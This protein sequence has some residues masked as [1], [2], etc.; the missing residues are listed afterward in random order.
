MRSFN[1]PWRNLGIGA[2]FALMLFA[3]LLFLLIATTTQ[4]RAATKTMLFLPQILPGIPIKPQEILL[5]SPVREAIQYPIA[6]GLGEADLYI[7]KRGSSHAGILLF[8]GVAPAGQD[9]PRVIGLAESLARSG[10]VVMIPWS[11]TMTQKRIAVEEVDN[12]VHAFQ[13]LQ[14]LDDTDPK[15]IGMSGFCVGA[16]LTTVAAQDPRIAKDV[17]FINFFGGYYDAKLLL[18]S[19]LTQHRFYGESTEPWAPNKLGVEVVQSHLIEGLDDSA[20]RD[21]LQKA[22]SEG[23]LPSPVELESL[24]DEATIVLKLLK[25]P[26]YDEVEALIDALPMRM[27]QTL[28]FISPSTNVDNLRARMLIM[29]DR[30]DNLVPSEESR[31]LVDALPES[32]EAYYTEFSLFDHVDP[33]QV[34]GPKDFA[35]E[36]FKLFLHMYNVMKE[37]S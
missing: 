13:Y 9:D 11:D 28:E 22:Y 2:T 3:S 27:K 29:H 36:A 24:S 21:L 10:A 31:R 25:Q 33:T 12:L 37:I 17:R 14:D 1:I 18:T 16:S 30:E 5:G 6:T 26:A 34:L 23:R 20:E 32:V 8:L 4:A 19:V 35:A 7:P 15:R